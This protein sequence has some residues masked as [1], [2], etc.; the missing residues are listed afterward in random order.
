MR[1]EKIKTDK[2][3]QTNSQTPTGNMDGPNERKG[4]KIDEQVFGI[5][6]FVNP[7]VI[8]PFWPRIMP[9]DSIMDFKHLHTQSYHP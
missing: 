5:N 2:K 6:R 3:T 8:P 7:L 1:E 4:D 9:F